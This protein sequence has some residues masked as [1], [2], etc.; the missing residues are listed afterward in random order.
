MG[1]CTR[2]SPHNRNLVGVS[3]TLLKHLPSCLIV[4]PSS[5]G[6]NS[7]CNRRDDEAADEEREHLA[8]MGS[9]GNTK[10]VA[11]RWNEDFEAV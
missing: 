2:V 5:V 10:C 3:E 9:W 6:A 1:Y 11:H 8:A 4:L 7:D